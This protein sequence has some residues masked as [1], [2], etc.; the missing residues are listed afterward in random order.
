MGSESCLPV[1]RTIEKLGVA[2]HSDSEIL[3]VLMAVFCRAE[4]GLPPGEG[5]R[6]RPVILLLTVDG[7][8]EPGQ[9]REAALL[10][11]RGNT[12]KKG[13]KFNQTG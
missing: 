7:E 4:A 8:R 13:T 11:N 3:A 10:S 5:Q 6:W 2:P 12:T 9:L 1:R